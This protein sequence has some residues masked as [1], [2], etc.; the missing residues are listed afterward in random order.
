MLFIFDGQIIHQC[1]ANLTSG[2]R[3]GYSI[4]PPNQQEK[5]CHQCGIGWGRKYGGNEAKVRG[6]VLLVRRVFGCVLSVGR[7]WGRGGDSATTAFISMRWYGGEELGG[8][9][10]VYITVP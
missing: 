7:P 10:V 9:K 6:R 8:E 4:I 1:A 3:G 2:G 5:L